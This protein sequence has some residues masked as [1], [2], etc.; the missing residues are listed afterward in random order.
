MTFDFNPLFF[1][2]DHTEGSTDGMKTEETKSCL[3]SPLSST[4]FGDAGYIE[5]AI[6]FIG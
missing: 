4:P 3:Q 5:F 6:A 2:S 1:F